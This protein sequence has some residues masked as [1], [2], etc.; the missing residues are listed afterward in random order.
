MKDRH[1]NPDQLHDA[2]GYHGFLPAE[3]TKIY[4]LCFDSEKAA[5]TPECNA[6]ERNR[7]QRN[8]RQHTVPRGAVRCL[9]YCK[10]M[11]INLFLKKWPVLFFNN[12]V[13]KI[14]RF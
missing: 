9:A 1:Q 5:L 6:T 13:V 11:P 12:S 14:S 7:T 4:C 10:R 8:A 3:P 2:I